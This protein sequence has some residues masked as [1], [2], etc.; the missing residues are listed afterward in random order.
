MKVTITKAAN[1]Q[2]TNQLGPEPKLKLNEV[3]TTG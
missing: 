2:L 1:E 3:R